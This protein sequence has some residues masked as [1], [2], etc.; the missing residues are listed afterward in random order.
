M[1][2]KPL[3]WLWG[4][5]PIAI[6]AWV[7]ALTEQ[8]RIEKDLRDRAQAAL[9]TAGLSWAGTSFNGRDAILT[10]QASED[11]E[12]D[13]AAQRLGEVWGV[14]VIDNRA[15]LL[16]KAD[17]YTWSATDKDNKVRLAG[18]VPN[19][20]TRKSILGF[21]KAAFPKLEV[22][23][24]MK[25]ARG[26]PPRD[27]W[28]A[29]TSFALNNL[30][31]LKSGTV[32]LEGV[33]FTIAGPAN[34]SAS[35]R[36]IKSALARPPQGIKLKADKVGLPVVAPYTWA[37]VHK[38]GEIMLSGHAPGEQQ[39][40]QM[41]TAVKSGFANR[42]VVDRIELADGAPEGFAV[43]AAEAIRELAKLDDGSAEL[44]GSQLTISG[45]A[46][47]EQAAEAVRKTL[48]EKIPASFK[49]SEAIKFKA[50]V[51]P[52]IEQY[53]TAIDAT[54]LSVALTGFAP[55]EAAK[56]LM[57]ETVKA[58]LPNRKIDNRLVVANGAPA[59]WQS[60]MQYALAGLGRLGGGKAQM[61]RSKLELR[62]E[63]GD[64]SLRSLPDELAL[65]V[66]SSCD[67]DAQVK[68]TSAEVAAR[69][70]E[71]DRCQEQ[72]ATVI[73]SGVILFESGSAELS[74]ASNATLDELTRSL[75]A[76]PDGVIEIEGHTDA[77]GDDGANQRLS[78]KRADA[79][80]GYFTNAGIPGDRLVTAGYGASK[81]VAPND[82]TEN[83]AKNRRIEFSVRAR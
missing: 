3:R 53:R 35:Y 80:R 66:G 34:D 61:M 51:V 49:T 31:H 21:A 73:K 27:A 55:S 52:T 74:S 5:V 79:V 32:E 50:A 7:A 11:K 59:G 76:C 39:H 65:A 54:S 36:T 48:K 44:K 25:L 38:Q 20:S 72:L 10:G 78:E 57:T 26:A 2:W 12:P 64:E 40:A 37:F 56:L 58:R 60:C 62:G 17:V 24:R 1:E 22:E 41:L 83:M 63:T 23:D 77:E 45:T 29:G 4:V 19:E 9:A 81:P 70:P 28:L 69:K 43:M 67:L 42:P 18:Y 68:L 16:E 46:A 82:T 75:K 71:R 30:V 13:Q 6:L 47:T 14:R 8:E 33:N 15:E